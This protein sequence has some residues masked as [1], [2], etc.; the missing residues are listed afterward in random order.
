MTR[1]L[2][3][4]LL[5]TALLSTLPSACASE[6]GAPAM[7]P[8]PPPSEAQLELA[9]P[10]PLLWEVPGPNGSLFL[11]GTIHV[12]D[13]AMVHEVVAARLAASQRFCMEV[14]PEDIS[15]QDVLMRGQAPADQPLDRVLGPE[16]FARVSALMPGVPDIFLKR[17]K[18][19]F[20]GVL[21]LQTLITPPAVGM[22]KHLWTE[23][24]QQEKKHCHLESVA[25]QLD[26]LERTFDVKAIEELVENPE[27]ARRTVEELMGAYRAGDLGRL[28]E[29]V[30]SPAMMASGVGRE[31][32]FERNE[33]WMPQ[34]L[35]LHAEGGVFVAVGAG[36]LPG[37]RGLLALLRKQGLEPKRVRV[38]E[39]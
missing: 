39:E 36:H 8:P 34:L 22:D 19:W 3:S 31:L 21:V 5:L 23:A 9:G 25:E 17:L 6:R 27:L 30:E 33:R 11:F 10:G 15:P 4:A 26:N 38:G 35:E 14:N 13:G 2:A 28:A 32:L 24:A 1:P 18:P 16:L 29:L 7:A 37:E 20:A 12:G